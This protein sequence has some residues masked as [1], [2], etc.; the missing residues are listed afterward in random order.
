MTHQTSIFDHMVSGKSPWKTPIRRIPTNQ[1]PPWRISH[2]KIPTQKIPARN[3]P[4]HIFKYF[5]FPLLLPLSLILVKRLYFCLLK[6][7]KFHLMRCIKKMQLCFLL[8]KCFGHDGNVFHIFIQEMLNF[9]KIRP[10][11]KRNFERI[12][13][14]LWRIFL[15]A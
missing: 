8:R 15:H 14:N 7:P 12:R 10:H 1:I 11:E 4:T 5:I 6:M 2:W 13:K 3:I 9:S